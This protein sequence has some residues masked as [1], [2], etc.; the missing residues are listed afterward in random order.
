MGIGMSYMQD[1]FP[2]Q[3]CMATS[4]YT[5][6]VIVGSVGYGLIFGATA[7]VLGYREMFALYAGF[8]LLAFFY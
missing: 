5:N 1:I 2:R 4:L 7:D 8:C 6:T 3:P